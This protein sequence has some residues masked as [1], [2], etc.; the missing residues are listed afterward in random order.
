MHLSRRLG[1]CTCGSA[2]DGSGSAADG[3]LSNLLDLTHDPELRVWDE[4]YNEAGDWDPK[5]ARRVAAVLE[6]AAKVSPQTAKAALK[7]KATAQDAARVGAG[8]SRDS[9]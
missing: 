3:G 2:A 8:G 4:G 1:A 6:E 9:N 5:L 7:K